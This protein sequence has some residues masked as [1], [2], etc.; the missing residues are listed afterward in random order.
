MRLILNSIMSVVN[1]KV[2][3]IRPLG[4]ENLKEWMADENN[5]YI[6][7]AGI[8]FIT[9][10]NTTIKE[11]FPKTSSLFANPFKIGKDGTRDE[12]LMKYESY[13]TARLDN[14]MKL[15]QELL[16]LK[17]KTLGCWCHPE[18]CHGNVLIKLIT[19]YEY[20]VICDWCERT[21]KNTLVYKCKNCNDCNLCSS[22][23]YGDDVTPE[24]VLHHIDCCEKPL[25]N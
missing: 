19:K 13:I 17:G 21:L 11:R 4:Y 5:V 16:N 12:V 7:R 6:G 24:G 3:S 25:F 14:D 1:C 18:P 23:L 2:N 20:A 22:C 10:T 8:V 9:T 15:R